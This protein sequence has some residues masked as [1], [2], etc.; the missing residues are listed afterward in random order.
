[1]LKNSW[2][3]PIG[4]GLLCVSSLPLSAQTAMTLT[5]DAS[6]PYAAKPPLLATAATKIGAPIAEA[7]SKQVVAA[8]TSQIR[9]GST[10]YIEPMDDNFNTY[11]AAA[12]V[13]KS[14]PLELVTKKNAAEY[15]V[16]GTFSSNDRVNPY[17]GNTLTVADASITV[18]EARTKQI[19]FAQSAANVFGNPSY[20]AEKCAN[21]LKEF[22]EKPERLEK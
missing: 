18:V 9:S 19:V 10:V 8:R 12:L 16:Q 2:I 1:M 21:R 7:K 22:I 3:I 5:K 14:V 13:E 11:L 4:V 20:H 6:D 17:G 15:L